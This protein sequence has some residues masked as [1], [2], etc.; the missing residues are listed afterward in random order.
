MRRGQRSHHRLQRLQ[1]DMIDPPILYYAQL[2]ARVYND[3][4][5][6]GKVDGAG[7]ACVYDGVV[8]FRGT[9]DPASLL[10]DIEAVSIPVQGLGLIHAGF[11][12]AWCEISAPMMRL[13][14]QTICGHSLGGALALIYAGELC[15]AGKPP[16]AVYC[17]EPPR[18]CIGNDLNALLNKCG[19][20]R[21]ASR[22][23]LDP[24]TEIPG[25]MSLPAPLSQIG[26]DTGTLDLIE[27]HLIDNVITAIS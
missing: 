10:T 5:Q 11:Y 4:P 16:A 20:M 21:G 17:F 8:T 1:P 12:N 7:R 23:G 25:W 15:A 13:A 26:R 3:P 24:V 6:Y 14:P 18:L 19:V 27:Y 9:D 22:N 2:C